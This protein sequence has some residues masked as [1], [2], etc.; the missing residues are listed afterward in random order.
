MVFGV[1]GRLI[2]MLTQIAFTVL[3]LSYFGTKFFIEFLA[4]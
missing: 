4:I 3:L 1:R 2:V